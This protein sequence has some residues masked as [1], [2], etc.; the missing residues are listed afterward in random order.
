MPICPIHSSAAAKRWITNLYTDTPFTMTLPGTP[1]CMHCRYWKL[2]EDPDAEAIGVCRRFPP[3]YDGWPMS[4]AD[5]W[6]GE[7]SAEIAS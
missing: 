4:R 7:Y 3:S 5:D 2:A 1:S 6:C